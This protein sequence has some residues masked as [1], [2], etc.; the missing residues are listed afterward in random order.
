MCATVGK[1]WGNLWRPDY[2]P[3]N[4]TA[5]LQQIHM[6]FV[7]DTDRCG[8]QSHNHFRSL[9]CV[10]KL[11]ELTAATVVATG[12]LGFAGLVLST[13]TA[14]AVVGAMPEYRW[15]PGENFDPGWGNNWEPNTCHDDF[16]RDGDGG[17]HS[18]DY[19]GFDNRGG[20]Y[21]DGPPG[22]YYGPPGY[23]GPPPPPGGWA[24]PP[25]CIPFVNC[26]PT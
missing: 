1:L 20:D 6:T 22:N 17:D 23:N 16:H 4:R 24:T 15:C 9:Q 21:R 13:G 14:G 10:R 26:P 18:R 12:T 19:R 5:R 7:V 2:F 25:F 3:E 8:P 11:V